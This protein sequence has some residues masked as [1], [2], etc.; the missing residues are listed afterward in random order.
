VNEKNI[1]KTLSLTGI[2]SFVGNDR[3]HGLTDKYKVDLHTINVSKL[4]I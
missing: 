4:G 2:A 1:K 3:F